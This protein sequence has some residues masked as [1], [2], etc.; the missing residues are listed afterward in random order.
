MEFLTGLTG[1]PA[2]PLSLQK[3]DFEEGSN[4]LARYRGQ[5]TGSDHE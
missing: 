4:K 2:F 1:L 5:S 3:W